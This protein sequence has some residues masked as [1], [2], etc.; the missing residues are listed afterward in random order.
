[1]L[2]LA[3]GMRMEP[4][5]ADR[6]EYRGETVAQRQTS[7]TAVPAEEDFIAQTEHLLA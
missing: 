1:M 7:R 2:I 3:A 4:Q 5:R 6:Q